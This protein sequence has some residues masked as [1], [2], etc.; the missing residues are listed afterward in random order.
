MMNNLLPILLT[1]FACVCSCDFKS[2]ETWYDGR[3]N[4]N[5]HQI[6]RI[7]YPHLDEIFF[8]TNIVS[9]IRKGDVN[10][11]E[12]DL[13]PKMAAE[14]KK[15]RE[16]VAT[17]SGFGNLRADARTEEEVA[18]LWTPNVISIDITKPV[19]FEHGNGRPLN[20]EDSFDI[21]ISSAL[22]RFLEDQVAFIGR[23]ALKRFPYLP[24]P[25]SPDYKEDPS[26][27]GDEGSD[28]DCSDCL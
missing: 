24:A 27:S 7:G 3:L 1:L 20:G 2:Q 4:A 17:I 11:D 15:S 10:S 16:F 12:T 22:G 26:S 19:S 14:L 28:D 25:R 5:Y 8:G 21:M 18:G 6:D 23:G 9:M 13:T